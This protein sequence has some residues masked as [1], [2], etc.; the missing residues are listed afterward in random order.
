MNFKLDANTRHRALLQRVFLLDELLD[1]PARLCRQIQQDVTIGAIWA[2][3]LNLLE[4]HHRFD[5]YGHRVPGIAAHFSEQLLF[6]AS[7]DR[8][9]H[10]GHERGLKALLR[11]HV[12]V[13]VRNP[14]LLR[15]VFHRTC[16]LLL[17]YRVQVCL[18][19]LYDNDTKQRRS[20]KSLD[21]NLARLRRKIDRKERNGLRPAG[22]D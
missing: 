20:H 17:L 5:H 15:Q 11:R 4:L 8:V 16:L 10:L 1:L 2:D 12:A 14:E 13:F 7:E 21:K 18:F 9:V 6:L 22:G 3:D 19:H